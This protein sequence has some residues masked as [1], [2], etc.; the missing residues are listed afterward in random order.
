MPSASSALTP[1]SS[2]LSPTSSQPRRISTPSSEACSVS[3]RSTVV[4]G[5][6]RTYGC[7]VSSPL[8][9]GFAMPAKPKPP[10]GYCWPSARNRSSRP[11]WSIT[12]TLRA[13]RPSARTTLVGSASFSSTGACTP[14]SR[15]S[16]A[17]ITPV[18]PPPATITSI[19][20]IPISAAS[21]FDRVIVRHEPGLAAS[22]PVRDKLRVAREGRSRAGLAGPISLERPYVERPRGCRPRALALP[23][24]R[25]S[26]TELR[27]SGTA[28]L[29]DSD[30]SHP[31]RVAPP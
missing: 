18:G 6:P 24:R 9:D 13:C 20:T 17:S 15:N 26:P 21:R 16:L 2:W 8:G 27:G 12:S 3:R 23:L 22:P 28:A 7:A 11:R 10:T 14:C 29:S 19:I 4:C 1:W 30:Q 25:L 31:I 5:M